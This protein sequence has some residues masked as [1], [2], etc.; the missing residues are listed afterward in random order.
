MPSYYPLIEDEF[1]ASKSS[2]WRREQKGTEK[3]LKAKTKK[4]EKD[5]MKELKKDTI[6]LQH[7]RENER[8]WRKNAAK[9][10]TFKLG[11]K[12]IRDEV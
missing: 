5:A 11:Q 12:G 9:R 8:N 1:I 3:V 7:E 10:T 2:A 6:I 4:Y